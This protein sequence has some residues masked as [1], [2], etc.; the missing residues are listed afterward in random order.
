MIPQEWRTA[1]IYDPTDTDPQPRP[2]HSRP[3]R[4]SLCLAWALQEGGGAVIYEPPTESQKLRSTVQMLI[5]A[6]EVAM[7]RK[8]NV[9]PAEAQLIRS[10]LL[11][12]KEL[13]HEE[14]DAN[15]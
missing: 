1:R 13:T 15:G 2:F 4:L 8:P 3:S 9:T 12:A 14:A 5:T 11:I 6:L 7:K 10:A